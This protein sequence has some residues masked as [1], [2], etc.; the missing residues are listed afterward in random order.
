MESPLN[1][2]I[3]SPNAT[4]DF[5]IAVHSVIE[6]ARAAGFSDLI[7]ECKHGENFSV[8]LTASGKSYQ[9]TVD[10]SDSSQYSIVIHDQKSQLIGSITTLFSQ[11]KDI[12]RLTNNTQFEWD[13]SPSEYDVTKTENYLAWLLVSLSLDFT[14]EDSALISR[15][16]QHVSCET[17]PSDIRYFPRLR[18]NELTTIPRKKTQCFGLYPVVDSI[19][20]IEEL[21]TCGV[22]I[23][24][25]RVKD[26]PESEVEDDVRR[27]IQVGKETGV[28]IVIN[29]YW[30]LALEHSASCIHL[31]QEDL[32]A[33]EDSRILDSDIGLGISTHGYFEIINAL[34]YKPSYLALGHIFPTTTK[35][36]PSSPQGLIKLKLYQSLIVSIGKQRG[37]VLPSVAIGGIDL[38]RAPLVIETGVTSVAVVRAVTL[39]DD[40]KEAVDQFQRLFST[41]AL[42]HGV[43]HAH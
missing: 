13:F 35:D 12:V 20:L 30:G 36:M 1:S 8:N 34:Q 31:G 22:K 19:E 25:L 38:E 21:A 9:L 24:Q 6:C 14:L 26:K 33:L 27:A 15:S 18:K 37:S 39:A 10:D 43:N 4:P 3:Q 11:S 42:S 16:A 17:W 28:D 2:F 40:K 41:E 7:T 5:H 23:L 32:A 29:D